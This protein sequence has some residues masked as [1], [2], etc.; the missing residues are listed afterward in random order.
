[1]MV[2]EL[3]QID[4]PGTAFKPPT[5]F[6]AA[7]G[8]CGPPGFSP[9]GIKGLETD[10]NLIIAGPLLGGMLVSCCSP[11]ASSVTGP[12]L[13]AV[14][15][16]LVPAVPDPHLYPYPTLMHHQHQENH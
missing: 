10:T 3:A 16:K 6:A 7:T 12:S 4:G 1:M 5:N 14:E 15:Q 11:S 2:R 9:I 13:F 8:G